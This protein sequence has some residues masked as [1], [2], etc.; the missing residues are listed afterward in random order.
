MR[1]SF[2][3]LASALVCASLAL[4]FKAGGPGNDGSVDD[5]LI[6]VNGGRFR[7][8]VLENDDATAVFVLANPEACGKT[9]EE[10]TKVLTQTQE[11]A[12]GTLN[13]ATVL[14][15]GS[16][17][18]G[19][20][21]DD[22]SV[23]EL[24]NVTA[25]PMLALYPP[26]PKHVKSALQLDPQTTGSLLA[27]G[28]KQTYNTLSRML[29]ASLVASVR[30]AS[31]EEFFT[32]PSTPAGLPRVVLFTD[33]KEKSL[34]LRKLSTDFASR[35]AFGQADINE[36]KGKLAL[37]FGLD[38]NKT[39]TAAADGGKAPT[40]VLLIS[41]GPLSLPAEKDALKKLAP[42]SLGSLTGEAGKNKWVR[43]EGKLDYLSLY[44]ALDATL[45]R[46]AAP[47]LRTQADFSKAC[48]AAS[49]VT[50]CFIA[51][52]PHE[53]EAAALSVSPLL[54]A[55]ELQK[56]GAADAGCIRSRRRVS[57][58]EASDDDDEEN[59]DDSDDDDD[60]DED[61]EKSKKKREAKLKKRKEVAAARVYRALQKVA[62]RAFVRTDWSSLNSGE[63]KA[64]R[65]PIS[66]SWVDA[67]EQS[68]F[69]EAFGKSPG[70]QA[71]A[72]IAF[73]PRKKKFAVMKGSF[74]ARNSYDFIL[75]LANL[76]VSP[77]AG[78]LSKGEAAAGPA[79]TFE[80]LEANVVPKLKDQPAPAAKKAAGGG[81]K[82]APAKK[83]A[84]KEESDNKKQTADKK[85]NKGKSKGGEKEEL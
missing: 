11:K 25:I 75:S 9:C 66:L 72:L 76:G 40:S 20:N 5:L 23:A 82:K 84:K 80:N 35:A 6:S 32:R 14:A 68:A 8:Y 58:F 54:A 45:P 81:K 41:S 34:L 16:V 69:V 42:G 70:I 48:G 49:D 29:G 50:L 18:P 67:V 47:Q 12:L 60:F 83:A 52:L 4:D 7:D 65:L 62:S 19:G 17:S 59:K 63:L 33:K 39:T 13:M 3:A 56:C 77:A 85:E 51:V 31:I 44:E 28:P 57:G 61:D 10:I 37:A 21:D 43:Y 74:S 53:A 26:G 36:G 38:T 64:E 46:A 1:L 79:V 78:G 71:P 24:W 73:N 30:Q 15:S 2:L 27:A 55:D 22:V